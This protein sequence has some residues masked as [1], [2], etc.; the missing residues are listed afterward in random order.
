MER[1]RNVPTY[2]QQ[3]I[4][5]PTMKRIMESFKSE[6]DLRNP[7]RIS[8]ESPK[9]L[10]PSRSMQIISQILLSSSTEDG[11]GTFSSFIHTINFTEYLLYAKNWTEYLGYKDEWNI[12]L[13][14][15]H[16]WP[17][18]HIAVAIHSLNLVCLP[19]LSKQKSEIWKYF[20]LRKDWGWAI[21]SSGYLL[22][23]LYHF[24]RK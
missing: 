21:I 2:I 22:K 1:R 8:A 4:E 11:K 16:R 23:E 13:V 17:K 24:S 19:K 18:R 14:L 7:T 20:S 10:F 6:K 3:N 15:I 12:S 9:D 5:H